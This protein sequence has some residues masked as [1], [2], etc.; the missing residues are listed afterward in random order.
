MF[1][2]F[3]GT[4]THTHIIYYHYYYKIVKI[5]K[6]KKLSEMRCS[7]EE[8]L[9]HRQEPLSI[10]PLGKR[11]FESKCVAIKFE[12]GKVTDRAKSELF[13]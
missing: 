1:V 2:V 4:H 11:G 7:T 6:Q 8:K 3:K 12:Y 9:C 13:I 5:T 10:S